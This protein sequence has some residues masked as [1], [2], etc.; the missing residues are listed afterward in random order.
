LRSA[1]IRQAIGKDVAGILQ[2]H[3]PI[4]SVGRADEFLEQIGSRR[5][6]ALI[7]APAP[8]SCERGD[9]LRHLKSAGDLSPVLGRKTRHDDQYFHLA[10]ATWNRYRQ[11]NLGRFTMHLGQLSDFYILGAAR[12][13]VELIQGMLAKPAGRLAARIGGELLR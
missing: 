7:Q 4:G 2:T 8:L 6:L 5:H 9:Q 1:T 10:V 12:Q 11:C 3:G 13:Q